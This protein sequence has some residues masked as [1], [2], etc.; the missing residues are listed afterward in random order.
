[1]SY[2][3]RHGDRPLEGYTVLR[4]LGRGGFGEVYYARSDGG[5]ELAL[6]LIQQNTDIELR[7]VRECMNLKSPHLVTIFDVKESP[8]G[9]PPVVIMEYVR[10]PSLG[11]ILT[12]SP[13]GVG[14]ARAVFLLREIGKGLAY[15][16]DNGLV[17]RDLKPENIFYEASFVKIGDYGLAKSISVSRH[18]G[19]TMS[20]GTVHYMAPEI[21]SGNYSRGVDIYA[22]GI[23]F[24]ELLTGKVPFDGESMAEILMKHLTEKA[25]LSSIDP[26]L[27][28]VLEKALSKQ[29]DERYSSVST[30]MEDLLAAPGIAE[31]LDSLSSESLSSFDS[32]GV[33][34]ETNT[35]D[36][37]QTLI[38]EALETALPSVEDSVSPGTTTLVLQA[39]AKSAESAESAEEATV[40]T[41]PPP[42]LEFRGLQGSRRLFLG[43][44]TTLVMATA[45]GFF[46]GAPGMMPLLGFVMVIL[47]GAISTYF[48]E[49]WIVPR[50]EIDMGIARRL[51]I[52]LIVGSTLSCALKVLEFFVRPV[53]PFQD[54]LLAFFLAIVLLRWEPRVKRNRKEQFSLSQAFSAG[55]FGFL[56]AT[57]V[58]G[59]QVFTAGV[60]AAMSLILNAI[61]PF[62]ASAPSGLDARTAARLAETGQFHLILQQPRNLL[63]V[64]LVVTGTVVYLLVGFEIAATCLIVVPFLLSR[65]DTPVS[66]DAGWV[67][68]GTLLMAISVFV[69]VTGTLL[70]SDFQ[71]GVVSGMSVEALE[72]LRDFVRSNGH[73]V[74]AILLFTPAVVCLLLA[75]RWAGPGHVLRGAAGWGAAALLV[76]EVAMNLSQK[77]TD[78]AMSMTFLRLLALGI[79]S[80]IF[81]AWPGTTRKRRDTLNISGGDESPIA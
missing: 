60:L 6:K 70:A 68:V 25:D 32:L 46:V 67:A 23:I 57:I 59:S 24:Y 11:A 31:Q 69:A 45:L 8:G 5:R 13:G 4:G 64:V 22:L 54:S 14:I 20:I 18:S 19:Q 78:E 39:G 26:A 42:A 15:L 66:G 80:A 2:R 72:N 56:A 74:V 43:A 62:R 79:V 28:P 47:S 71:F 73:M 36:S 40:N 16:H 17:H 7:G 30:L 21:G 51:C 61:S 48:V 58:G 65:E 41:A 38:G 29:P 76:T 9:G 34:A 27:H 53:D 55:L 81:L 63:A 44:L 75:R 3:Y 50:Y 37:T 52:L 77:W 35:N 49:S 12:A 10:G 1:M 33:S